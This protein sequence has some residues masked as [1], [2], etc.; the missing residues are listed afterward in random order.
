MAT[1][2]YAGTGAIQAITGIGFQPRFLIV[3]LRE[4]GSVF[5]IGSSETGFKADQDG[6]RTSIM[7]GG[8]IQ[9]V[10]NLIVSFDVDGFTVGSNAFLNMIGKVY[11]YIVFG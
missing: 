7:S 10:L 3:Y 6:L 8:T 4:D 11:T 9:W 2:T 5:P 1:G